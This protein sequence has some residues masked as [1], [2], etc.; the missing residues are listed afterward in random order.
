[1]LNKQKLT[2]NMLKNERQ[3]TT[4]GTKTAKGIHKEQRNRQQNAF[5]LGA[6]Y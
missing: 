2:Q 5:T 3:N 6:A 4:Q 1:M